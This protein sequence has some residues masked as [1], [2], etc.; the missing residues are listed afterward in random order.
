MISSPRREGE[1]DGPREVHLLLLD[2]GRSHI[3]RDTQLI[4]TLRCIRCG[5][6]M[7]HC[8]VYGRIGGHAYGST[9]PGP[10]GSV[11]EP[12]KE[13][14]ARFGEL[15]TAST[16]CGACA[17]V[18]PVRIP[19]PDLLNRL[20][21]EGVRGDGDGRIRGQGSRRKPVEAWIWRLWSLG[22]RHPA[23][24]RLG[25]HL[26]TRLRSLLPARLGAWTDSR[27]APRVARTL[28]PRT[29]TRKGV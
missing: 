6:C 24:Y 10:I 29:G 16:L 2:N 13:G 11:V 8:P 12:Q 18:C 15:P 3:H 1:R 28:P 27:R 22:H 25:T 9:I 21:H 7:N 14:L 26:A 19:L 20:R 17:E 4:D 5:A 23:I